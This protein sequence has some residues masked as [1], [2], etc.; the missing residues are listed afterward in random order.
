MADDKI[1]IILVD[2]TPEIRDTTKRLLTLEPDFEVVGTASTGREAIQQSKEHE[3]DIIIMDI[4]MPDMD[5]I[6]ATKEI[7]STNPAV[8]IIMMSVNSDGDYMDRAMGA[9]A[10]GFIP[11]PAKPDKLRDRIR[12]VYT[13]LEPERRRRD[14]IKSVQAIGIKQKQETEHEG[15]RAGHVIV[16]YSPK[17]GAGTT[18]V[19]TNIASG[20]MRS[21]IK[22]LLVDA[23]VQFGDVGVFLNVKAQ[24]TIADIIENPEDIDA[25]LFDNIVVEHG[26]GLKVLLGP[27]RPEL[28]EPIYAN[29]AGIKEVIE[30]VRYQYDFIVVDTAKRLD[31]V[32]VNLCDIATEIL[33]IL[34]PTLPGVKSTRFVLDLFDQIYEDSADRIKLVLA[35]VQEERRG[36]RVSLAKDSITN[37]LKRDVY[38]SIPHDER[39][40]LQAINKGTPLIAAERNNNNAVV[41]EL[42]DIAARLRRT[43]LGEEEASEDESVDE[44]NA[45]GFV[46]GLFG[47]R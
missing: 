28:A 21:D 6:T 12:S 7:H 30:Q 1:K 9:G 39:A 10:R 20:L 43:H 4:N 14:A 45:G 46:G 41:K 13:M 18:T 25:D 19:A 15:E 11:K 40:L 26:S 44:K 3:P 38:A 37:Y 23:D 17:G 42:L 22:V 35:Q 27:P 32:T 33:L 2:D 31:E 16:C 24:S 47:R 36:G 5:G 8:G 29:P 34:P